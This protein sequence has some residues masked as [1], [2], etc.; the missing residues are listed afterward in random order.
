MK[1][2]S[3]S[4]CADL[5][6]ALPMVRKQIPSSHAQILGFHTKRC[7]DVIVGFVELGIIVKLLDCI[8]YYCIMNPP[9]MYIILGAYSSKSG[10]QLYTL[11][12]VRPRASLARFL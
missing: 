5:I 1:V 11:S 12:E 8:C 9:L 7:M 10:C 2:V 6:V 3:F 4:W